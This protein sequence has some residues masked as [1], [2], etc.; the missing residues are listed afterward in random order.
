M[1]EFVE[2]REIRKDMFAICCPVCG[3]YHYK[4]LEGHGMFTC[5]KCKKSTEVIVKDGSVTLIARQLW[6]MTP[7]GMEASEKRKK[8]DRQVAVS[9]MSRR[10]TGIECYASC[11]S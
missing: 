11:L 7:D 3:K 2:T 6:D 8:C 4:M 10:R 5:D 9:G 1:E